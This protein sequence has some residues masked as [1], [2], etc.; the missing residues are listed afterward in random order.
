MEQANKQNVRV[1][2]VM[3]CMRVTNGYWYKGRRVIV[4]GI[5]G[6]NVYFEDLRSGDRD[7]FNDMNLDNFDIVSG[8]TAAFPAIGQMI[9]ILKWEISD[10]ERVLAEKKSK[11]QTLQEAVTILNEVK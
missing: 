4:V 6:N 9:D 10:I 2:T 8:S 5:E 11:L 7:W 3:A 1:G